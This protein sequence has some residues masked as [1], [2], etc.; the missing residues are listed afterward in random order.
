MKLESVGQRIYFRDSPFSAKDE[1]KRTG[2]HW[3]PDAKSWWLGAAKR[4]VAEALLAKIQEAATKREAE[5]PPATG[6][7]V[8]VAGNTYA[9][10]DQLRA[11]GA[12]W[13]GQAK[14]WRVPASRLGAANALVASAP[15]TFRY[16]SCKQCG[17]R[18][19]ARGWPRIYKNGIC[20]DCY[21]DMRDDY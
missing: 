14:V 21:R 19:N 1:I 17:A 6:A 16:T 10:R 15:K 8:E 2:A 12:E 5:L 18:P 20:S 4:S 9:V 13:D 3:D 7:M 11:M